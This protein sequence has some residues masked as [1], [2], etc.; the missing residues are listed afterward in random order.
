MG[1]CSGDDLE[2]K[3]ENRRHE[4]VKVAGGFLREALEKLR[5]WSG[6]LKSQ[7]KL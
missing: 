6:A 1:K 2:E 5:S 3:K 7:L 4:I